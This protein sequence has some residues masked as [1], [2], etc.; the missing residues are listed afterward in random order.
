MQ[1]AQ[2]VLLFLVCFNNSARI[3]IYGVTC[4]S[5]SCPFLCALAAPNVK[6]DAFPMSLPHKH[7]PQKFLENKFLMQEKEFTSHPKMQNR[8]QIG[9]SVVMVGSLCSLCE[10]LGLHVVLHVM[11]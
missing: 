4:S 8:Y 9:L 10:D 7:P 5:S 11:K 2:G 6:L 3:E 1:R